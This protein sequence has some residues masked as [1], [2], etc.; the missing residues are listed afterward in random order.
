[1]SLCVANPWLLLNRAEDFARL[2]PDPQALAGFHFPGLAQDL[3]G[4][5]CSG[6][7]HFAPQPRVPPD[8]Q[9][10][11]TNTDSRDVD[12]G[13]V[14]DGAASLVIKPAAHLAT[15]KPDVPETVGYSQEAEG[16]STL[17]IG[18]ASKFF[19][20]MMYLRPADANLL[21][22]PQARAR[23][24]VTPGLEAPH[25]ATYATGVLLGAAEQNGMPV[26]APLDLAPGRSAA[27]S[28]DIFAGPKKRDLF[29]DNPLY[30]R[31]GYLNTIQFGSSCCGMSFCTFGWL[32]LWL[33]PV[34][35]AWS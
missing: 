12:I 29:Q 9:T 22:D 33:S 17:W 21:V 6:K 11:Q 3:S 25:S 8:H 27:A 20:S 14:K 31:V 2:Q 26:D 10:E 16:R 13:K 19:G 1:M 30:Q 7:L 4:C 35:L 23:F 5:R 32:S 24:S 28:F 34:A 15:M 18:V